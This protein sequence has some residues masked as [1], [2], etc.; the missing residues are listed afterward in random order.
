MS[1]D[2]DAA[3]TAPIETMSAAVPGYL[4]LKPARVRPLRWRAR[5]EAT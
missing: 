2:P 4:D 1:F 5:R 3:G